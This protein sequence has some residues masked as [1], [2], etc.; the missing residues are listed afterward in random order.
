MDPRTRD[1]IRQIPEELTEL[2]ERLDSLEELSIGIYKLVRST[3]EAIVRKYGKDKNT[4]AKVAEE[5]EKIY[6]KRGK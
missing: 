1:A 3:N 2:K 5:I 4:A 6:P